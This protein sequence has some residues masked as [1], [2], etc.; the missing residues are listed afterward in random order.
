MITKDEV[1]EEIVPWLPPAS[2]PPSACV[3]AWAPLKLRGLGE[4]EGGRYEIDDRWTLDVTTCT[5][6]PEAAVHSGDLVVWLGE[7]TEYRGIAVFAPARVLA[8]ETMK[9][10]RERIWS[11][12]DTAAAGTL[13]EGCSALVE[14]PA[15][16]QTALR[17]GPRLVGAADGAA[18]RR[19]FRQLDRCP[20]CGGHTQ[21]IA[22]GYQ[23]PPVTRVMDP[24]ELEPQDLGEDKDIG[25][26]VLS[27]AQ[28]TWKCLRCNAIG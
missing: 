8:V 6:E 9:G 12:H 11:L 24:A 16:L 15:D 23:L 28:P 13:G 20:R 26:C 22:Y 5:G 17:S 3:D 14:L 7:V 27:E 4:Y 18:I 21:Q 25:G 19:H 2:A 10:K 1:I